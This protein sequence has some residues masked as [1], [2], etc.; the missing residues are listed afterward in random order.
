MRSGK[1][2]VHVVGRAGK[3]KYK[4]RRQL[5]TCARDACRSRQ[6][7]TRL[8][9]HYNMYTFYKFKMLHYH[10]EEAAGTGREGRAYCLA[11]PAGKTHSQ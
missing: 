11:W 1:R 10:R 7:V 8:Q 3:S 9:G 2:K 5:Q 6:V 4:E